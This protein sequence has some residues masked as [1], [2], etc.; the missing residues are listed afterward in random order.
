MISTAH[1]NPCRTTTPCGQYCTPVGQYMPY[2]HSL[3]HCTPGV[4]AEPNFWH[5]LASFKLFYAGFELT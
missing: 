4:A 2:Y 3:C 1:T 5:L